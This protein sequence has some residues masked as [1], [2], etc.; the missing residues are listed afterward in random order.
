MCVCVCV[1]IDMECVTTNRMTLNAIK[2]TLITDR[3]L[4]LDLLNMLDKGEAR[5]GE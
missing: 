5:V 1:C 3:G 4:K 2:A